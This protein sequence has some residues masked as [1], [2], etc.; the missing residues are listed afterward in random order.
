MACLKAQGYTHCL[1]Q[2]MC[3]ATNPNSPA[4]TLIYAVASSPGSAERTCVYSNSTQYGAYTYWGVVPESSGGSMT[5]DQFSMLIFAI[6]M[7][8]FAL[9]VGLGFKWTTKRNT[10]AGDA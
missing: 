7:V 2:P 6:V 3:P 1:L 8:I 5:A 10:Y 4:G 9:G